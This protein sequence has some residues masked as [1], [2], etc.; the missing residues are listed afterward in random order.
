MQVFFQVFCIMYFDFFPCLVCRKNKQKFGEVYKIYKFEQSHV[1]ND[2]IIIYNINDCKEVKILCRNR[3]N[4]I[5]GGTFMNS[6][7]MSRRMVKFVSRFVL[8]VAMICLVVAALPADGFKVAAATKDGQ[9]ASIT[10]WQN[11]VETAASGDT[12]NVQLTASFDV[13][14][15]NTLNVPE[16]VTVNLY[17]CGKTISMT[18]N[19]WENVDMML[20]NNKGTLNIYAGTPTNPNSGNSFLKVNNTRTG[21]KAEVGD[22]ELCTGNLVAVQN[23]NKIVV[24]KGV[25]INA[26]VEM[27]YSGATL[28][29]LV[30]VPSGNTDV[31]TMAT[32][33]Y[34]TSNTAICE[35]NAASVDA[36]ALSK[37]ITY[38]YNHTQGE[39][40][41]ARAILGGT[42]TVNG[43]ST[44]NAHAETY[45]NS[46][47]QNSKGVY[48][49]GESYCIATAGNIT[50]NGG[51]FTASGV[52]DG[53]DGISDFEYSTQSIGV[54][55]YKN[56]APVVTDG[57]FSVKVN[58][59]AGCENGLSQ[60]TISTVQKDFKVP[61]VSNPGRSVDI[62][63]T[64]KNAASSGNYIDETGWAHTPGS[65]GSSGGIAVKTV[66]RG[67]INGTGGTVN[68]RIHVVY[69]FWETTGKN[70]LID[71]KIA[72][73]DD[74]RITNPA[75]LYLNGSLLKNNTS[76]VGNNNDPQTLTVRMY[77]SANP[78]YWASINV[79]HTAGG[80]KWYNDFVAEDFSV[81]GS[82]MNKVT[83][84]TSA[85]GNKYVEYS[86]NITDAAP[87]YVY[88]D[89]V[90][91]PTSAIQ[92][93]FGS[94][95]I[96]E[97]TYTGH[98]PIPNVTPGFPVKI[99][100]SGNAGV[101]WTAD[102]N[103]AG[104]EDDSLLN[105]AYRYVNNANDEDAGSGLP[106][107]AGTYTITYTL[108]K[109]T[110]I[111]R[112]DE[113]YSKNRNSLSGN[114]TLRINKA[115]ALR[116]NLTESLTLTYGEKLGDKLS[117][118]GLQADG[119]N[120][121]AP[122]GTFMFTNGT[123]DSNSY[124]SVCENNVLQI[125]WNPSAN[126]VNY[127]QTTFT[128]YY[129]VKPATLTI[130]PTAAAVVY[131]NSEFS[132][133]YSSVI[134]GLVANDNT[135]AKKESILAA[136]AYT[137]NYTGTDY[138]AYVPGGI[139]VGTYY[140]Q[141]KLETAPSFLSN[142]NV[143]YNYG[144]GYGALAVTA[145]PLT[146]YAE[147][148]SRAYNPTDMTATVSLS[149]TDGI[150]EGDIVTISP[151]VGN[152][153]VNTVGKQYVEDVDKTAATNALSGADYANYTVSF[154]TFAEGEAKPLVEI[155]KA[156]PQV[157]TPVV[158]GT[159]YYTIGGRLSDINLNAG[160]TPAV[161]GTWAWDDSSTN[162]QVLVKTYPATFT[163]VDTDNY[164][165]YSV[166]IPVEIL[167]SDVY[168]TYN[169]SLTYGD[170]RPDL[171]RYSYTCATDTAFSIAS[172][173]T[174]GNIYP[175]TTYDQF[176]GV[177]PEGYV[178]TLTNSN[179]K[180]VNGNYN[181]II[182]NGLITVSPK[183]ITVI[184]DDETITYGQSFNTLFGCSVSYSDDFVGND[185]ANALT[186]DGSEPNYIF[187]SNYDYTNSY[188]AG[189]Y[190]IYVNML[191][192]EMSP[193]YA[194]TFATGTLKVEKAEL[195]VAGKDVTVSYGDSIDL[196]TAYVLKGLTH[197]DT[198]LEQA[199]IGTP[200]PV[201]TYYAGA[202]V[203]EEG[204]AYYFDFS[205]VSSENYR[206]ST[207][208][209]KIIVKKVNPVITTAPTASVPFGSALSEAVFSNFVASVDGQFVFDASDAK[210]PYSATP[211]NQDVIVYSASFIPADTTNYN[212][213]SNQKVVLT[214][215]KCIITGTPLI[216][217]YPM[218]GQKLTADL[219][220]M[221]PAGDTNYTFT[222]TVNGAVVST[223]KTYTVANANEVVVLT[224]TAAGAY[225]G[226]ANA[227]VTASQALTIADLEKILNITGLSDKTYN[228]TQQG[229]DVVNKDAANVLMGDVTVK[230]NGSATIPSAAGTYAVTVDIALPDNF[231][232]MTVSGDAATQTYVGVQKI[233]APVSNMVIGTFKI[234]P[235][236][237]NV[238]VKVADKVYDGTN[239]A[240][241][242]NTEIVNGAIFN[243]G[244]Q[245]DVAFDAANASYLF[246][247]ADVGTGKTVTVGGAALVGASKDNYALTV[248]ILNAD[249]GVITAKTLDA[250]LVAFDREYEAG[251]KNVEVAFDIDLSTLAAG[252]TDAD[253]YFNPITAFVDS[254]KAGRQDVNVNTGD[255]VLAGAKAGNY[256]WNITNLNN[257]TVLI[258]KATP[259]Y[260]MPEVGIL[261]YDS[262]R[263]LDDISLGDSRWSW[264]NGNVKPGAGTVTYTAVFMPDDTVNYKTVE[265]EVT[266]VINKAQIV[267]TATSYTLTY[268]DPAPTYGY[269]VTGLT[270]ADTLSSVATGYAI[271]NCAY[272]LGSPV[273]AD[274]YPVTV[275]GYYSS[276]NYDF[277]YV[278]GLVTVNQRPL[279][280]NATVT[281]R[282]FSASNYDV[283]ITF[284]QPTNIFVADNGNVALATY[285]VTGTVENNAA[286]TRLVNYT[287]P[288]LTG[289]AA[290][291]Y[292]LV[293][294]PTE[295]TVEILKAQPLNVVMPT[296]ATVVYGSP[297]S[298]AV[299]TSS[300]EGDGTFRLENAASYPAAHGVFSDVYKVEFIPTDSV[301]FATMTAYI[302]LTVEKKPLAVSAALSG[303]YTEGETLYVVT[304]AIENTAAPYIVYEWY[305]LNNAGDSIHTGVKLA[306]GVSY[307][308]TD[309]DVGYYVACA[310]RV[311]NAAPYYCDAVAVSDTQ[312]TEVY[313]TFWQKLW[314]WF[315]SI[316]SSIGQLFG[317]MS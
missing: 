191:A 112:K 198:T 140:I 155:V 136:L 253:V 297:L 76:K 80:S 29:G 125:T 272:D 103:L 63:N 22:Y 43:D 87:F 18:N 36:S 77:E 57:N 259:D 316:F 12:V 58:D 240:N 228:A 93:T 70:D 315:Y 30:W 90:K 33:I 54:L 180:D 199:V 123:A 311:D 159:R 279:Y 66:Q 109:D 214:I 65:A 195:V 278:Q 85:A 89:Y 81:K 287:A 248:E 226:S 129:T 49:V 249:N 175:S 99:I 223:E 37:G 106:V 44:I 46:A 211:Y 39:F 5:K 25:N 276:A 153:K 51:N 122:G 189:T 68:T 213:L 127:Q 303:S 202:P 88:V 17:M 132:T 59:A 72:G 24:N 241:A 20:L 196:T 170:P 114:F 86:F 78:Y 266:L 182:A 64:Y 146:V 40:A 161:D 166:N 215:E 294:N 4:A 32:G 242:V 15:G 288:V 79:G 285:S 192:E 124:K 149:I 185:N 31:L 48:S 71:Y 247:S 169:A 265:K 38:D 302:T 107:N 98:S 13:A 34:N 270:G 235:A 52:Y 201:S 2:Y 53:E 133:K 225:T 60:Y 210:P 156:V 286:G 187:S 296:T 117:L 257:V 69:R 141:P 14:Y 206:I 252:D 11:V 92:A 120:N 217:G 263:T 194:I 309:K 130:S 6:T 3:H 83:E 239:I 233:Y 96:A 119:V 147:A 301:N 251:N 245:D 42:V 310:V 237:F 100:K 261:T 115:Y 55:A 91:A 284:S 73:T 200:T 312:I 256:V 264:A 108:E 47:N 134:S 292:K 131:G 300:K 19:G 95:N 165:T 61:T 216:S 314:A 255:I 293:V 273:R 116:G 218:Q 139:N 177:I 26:Y 126:A 104:V 232:D 150:F 138:I 208:A 186:K 204:Y 75:E 113:V 8:V 282:N 105:V 212:V 230:Y 157:A 84:G 220:A 143:V 21:M 97:V 290:G 162:P 152:L 258:D 50:V 1:D 172:V 274:G 281:N 101:D 224:V 7:N 246:D 283:A 308:L 62:F 173:V 110:E 184:A 231:A 179:Y 203:T 16:G 250:A 289:S 238:N 267:I 148:V 183:T 176:D 181:L 167:A 205:G 45:Y 193:N 142:Y 295:L 190:T 236:A 227:S 67:A 145:R 207:T 188:K 94:A 268:G 171:T 28:S 27:Q 306:E 209:G 269:T 135:D 234:N 118:N 144:E 271:A 307:T 158:T 178:V 304:S 299:F 168:I 280:T 160:Y 164:L 291:N 154:M 56:N 222:W 221:N 41:F 163:P 137:I 254:D 128:V 277:R 23:S 197:G 275:T 313:K 174:S 82:V 229:I 243:N 244:I 298:T 74:A 102:Y 10:T 151:V 219:S 9:V 317:K 262:G 260:P 305:R 121:D 35:I 111:D